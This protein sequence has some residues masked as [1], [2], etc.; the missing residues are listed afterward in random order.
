MQKD[1]LTVDQFIIQSQQKAADDT[2]SDQ[3][4]AENMI[5]QQIPQNLPPEQR[6]ALKQQALQQLSDSQTQ[7]LQKNNE[8]IL[9]EGRKQLSQM[10]GHDLAG[11]EKIT[12]VFAGLINKK[13]NDFFQ[14][15]ISGDSQSASYLYV[16]AIIL[17]LTLL[18][19]SVPLSLLW[20]AII[21]LIFKLLV[22]LGLVEIQTVTVQREMII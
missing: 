9:Q 17:F 11:N 12:D 3:T 10:V 21:I 20:F 4:L 1:G 19:L 8:L 2:T 22:H 5:D 13:I 16:L 7:L 6:E 15:K 14:P 18:S